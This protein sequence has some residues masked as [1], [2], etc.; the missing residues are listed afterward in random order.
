M[1]V[2]VST[3]WRGSGASKLH[4]IHRRWGHVCFISLFGLRLDPKNCARLGI[5]NRPERH[6]REDCLDVIKGWVHLLH[7]F[8][9]QFSCPDSRQQKDDR[10]E[11][12]G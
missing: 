2:G 11:G 10:T 7:R 6:S 5:L 8:R 1:E 9:G 12:C 3:D 4:C